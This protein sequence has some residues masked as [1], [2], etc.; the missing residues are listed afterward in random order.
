MIVLNEERNA[1]RAQMAGLLTQAESLN[2]QYAELK[3]QL[4]QPLPWLED[5]AMRAIIPDQVLAKIWLQNEN[6]V[7][8]IRQSPDVK[9]EKDGDITYVYLNFIYPADEALIVSCGGNIELKMVEF[10][11]PEIGGGNEN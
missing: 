10:P 6:L 2:A 8:A 1:I 5:T 3:A 4:N 7:N 11:E 9:A